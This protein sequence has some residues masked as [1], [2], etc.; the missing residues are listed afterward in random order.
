VEK[1]LNLGHGFHE[2]DRDKVV[3]ILDKLDHRF[4]GIPAETVR[5]ELLVKDR[6]HNDQ[7][8]TFEGHVAG[9]KTV[10]ATSVDADLW[11]AV[12]EVRDEFLR[13]FNA[14]K[15]QHRR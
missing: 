1:C 15:E 3:E 14:W 13:Q 9:M 6:E 10:V 8:V 12:A 7:K 5:L 2:Y 11:V 4:T